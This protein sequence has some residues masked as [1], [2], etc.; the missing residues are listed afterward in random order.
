MKSIH[1]SPESARSYMYIYI[2][3][4]HACAFCHH[5]LYMLDGRNIA[6]VYGNSKIVNGTRA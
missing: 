4:S 5:H 2:Y 3:S 1:E 6:L